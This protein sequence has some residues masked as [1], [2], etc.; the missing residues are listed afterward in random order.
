MKFLRFFSAVIS[1]LFILSAISCTDGRHAPVTEESTDTE[2]VYN[3]DMDI[4]ECGRI[5][6]VLTHS[7]SIKLKE[8]TPENFVGIQCVEVR[9]L[10]T[11]A[12]DAVRKGLMVKNGEASWDDF[13]ANDR[14]YIQRMLQE[15]KKIL[16]LYIPTQDETELKK[17][18]NLLICRSDVESAEL[19][20][21]F[22][23][24]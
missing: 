2:T 23:I 19:D 13:S 11:S 22:T 21:V 6:I 24:D 12:G 9:D 20:A 1:A 16:C 10:S 5:L 18:R 14:E 17:V 7:E 4:S 8:Y 3:L 15:Y